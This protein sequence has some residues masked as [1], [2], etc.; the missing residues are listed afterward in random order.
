M[1][2][3]PVQIVISTLTEKVH[4]RNS[5]MMERGS[6][7]QCQKF[8]SAPYRS[9]TLA[10]SLSVALADTQDPTGSLSSINTDTHTHTEPPPPPNQGTKDTV[11]TKLYTPALPGPAS[12]LT[13]R[14]EA[15][16]G[17][18]YTSCV[19]SSL[20]LTYPSHHSSHFSR[21]GTLVH[22]LLRTT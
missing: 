13:V 9:L 2:R 20:L 11:S 10:R 22:C 7:A 5:R 4:K 18:H 14:Q 19:F 15:E 1:F 16:N 17:S 12:S 3:C 6:V 8:T 21:P